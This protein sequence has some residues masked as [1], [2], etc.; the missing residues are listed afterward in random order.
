MRWSLDNSIVIK[1][2]RIWR[3]GRGV[4]TSRL[5]VDDRADLLNKDFWLVDGDHVPAGLSDVE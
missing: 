4:L 5:T 2:V 3:S 1:T